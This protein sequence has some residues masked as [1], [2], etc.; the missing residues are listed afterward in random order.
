VRIRQATPEDIPAIIELFNTNAGAAR[1]S[2][3]QYQ[4][5]LSGSST[6]K[7]ESERLA[8]V[9]E[10]KPQSMPGPS[11]ESPAIA[12]CMI[13]HRI[14]REWDLENIAVEE[15]CRRR[16][17]GS[18]LMMGLLEQAR[19]QGGEVIFAE[20]RRSNLGARALYGRTGFEEIGVRKDYYKDPRED[21]I[22][23]RLSLG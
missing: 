1:W 21:A 16:A 3:G 10:Y 7:S 14:G 22:Q 23:L 20:V 9:L 5:L 8:L 12:G 2:E 17:F 11:S 19:A 13:A 18:R 15:K 4:F 6:D